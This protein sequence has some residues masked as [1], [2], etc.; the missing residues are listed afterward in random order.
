[1][2][3]ILNTQV[4]NT[5]SDKYGD[6]FYILDSDVFEANY[7][8]LLNA[9]RRYYQKV[10]I[11]YSY[12]TNYTPAFVKIVD[13]LG[14]FAEIVSDMEMEIALRSGV[15]PSKIIW[16]GPIKNFHKVKELLLLG[17]TVNVDSLV[18]MIKI[19]EIA[20]D[21]PN[22]TIN[23]GI[24]C[25]YD[26]GDGVLSRFGL[27]VDS[28][29]F[30]RSLAIVNKVSN[31]RL[32]NLQ[33]HFA[34]RQPEFWTARAEGMLRIYERVVEKYGI[35]PQRLDLGGGIYG[36]MPDSLRKQLN[37]DLITYDDYAKRAAIVF[38]D[39]FMGD[40]EA[41]ELFIEPGTAIAG[42]SMRYVC[43]V[44]TIKN[45]RGKTIITVTG[46]QKNISMTGINPPI[47]VVSCGNKQEYFNDADIV[48]YTCIEGD[49]LQKG[50]NGELSIGDY[51]IINNCGSY[52]LV[53]KAPFIFPNCPV[54]DVS[55]D[56]VTVVKRQETFD[57]LFVTYNFEVG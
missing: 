20:K 3:K 40:D 23:V 41:P 35:R 12:K 24:R 17:G 50:F 49:I 22:K 44:K 26:V 32:I 56:G 28:E 57:D 25:N 14:G 9:F 42:D 16:N 18:E 37:I 8:E 55:K 29:D 4:L 53:M 54:L 6:A 19:S 45:I 39:Y 5:L 1:M 21:N 30:V 36:K 48:G 38:A 46:S 13:K 2:T 27:D 15:N 7:K 10:N 11:A 34:K 43:K 33:A 47:E 51:I 31:M 52:S